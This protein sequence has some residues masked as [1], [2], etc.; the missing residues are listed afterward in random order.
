MGLQ[1]PC[2]GEL[3]DIVKITSGIWFMPPRQC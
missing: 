3:I 2:D 1:K